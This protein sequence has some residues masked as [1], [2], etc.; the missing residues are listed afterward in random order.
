MSD[1]IPRGNP[2]KLIQ[3]LRDNPNADPMTG[4]DAAAFL[5]VP[6][7]SI[8]TLM[9]TAVRE[10]HLFTIKDGR[11]RS[12]TLTAPPAEEVEEIPFNAALWLDGDLVLSGVQVNADGGVLIT[13]EQWQKVQGLV[14]PGGLAPA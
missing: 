7:N 14:N 11:V 5:G 8:H 13:R 12:F 10:G 2:A 9:R 3:H 4:V 6:S 1:Y